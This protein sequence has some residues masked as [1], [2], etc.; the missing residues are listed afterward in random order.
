[1]PLTITMKYSVGYSTARYRCT[2]C[3]DGEHSQPADVYTCVFSNASLRS[4][5]YINTVAT[6]SPYMNSISLAAR[7]RPSL[8]VDAPELRDDVV[9]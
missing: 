8:V 2:C 4:A 6:Y 5:A 1:M 9:A 3:A 7:R